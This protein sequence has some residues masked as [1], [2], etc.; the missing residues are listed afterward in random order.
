MI[1]S[2]LFIAC[3][4]FVYFM[5]CVYVYDEL[6]KEAEEQQDDGE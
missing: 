4:L 3:G 2:L 1:Y 5:Y 6:R